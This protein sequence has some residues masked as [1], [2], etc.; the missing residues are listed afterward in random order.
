MTTTNGSPT[1][2]AAC[3]MPAI[4]RSK[5]RS[6]GC[7]GSRGATGSC[8][9]GSRSTSTATRR[10]HLRS[11]LP[12]GTDEWTAARL[13]LSKQL[14]HCLAQWLNRLFLPRSRADYPISR[15][16]TC[17]PP[18]WLASQ[19]DAVVA[20]RSVRYRSRCSRQREAR[21]AVSACWPSRRQRR[22]H[23]RSEDLA[24][25][26][27]ARRNAYVTKLAEG[28]ADQRADIL[29]VVAEAPMCGKPHRRWGRA[30]C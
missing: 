20:R 1:T 14:D 18:I 16:K 23:R 6:T 8:G 2:T 9:S 22:A 19:R 27:I 17:A 25:D 13:P 30:V 24:I 11:R 10:P 4:R 15:S 12:T 7:S 3:S 21:R 26:P 5:T 28:T 29:P